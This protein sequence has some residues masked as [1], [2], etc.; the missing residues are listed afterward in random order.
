MFAFG[1]V[2][3]IA[4]ILASET[5]LIPVHYEYTYTQESFDI[6]LAVL[7][8]ILILI[9]QLSSNYVPLSSHFM[10]TLTGEIGQRAREIMRVI[11]YL[12]IFCHL[13]VLARIANSSAG[14]GIH[15]SLSTVWNGISKSYL[16]MRRN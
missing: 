5:S 13:Q 6:V 16:D 4:V 3:V 8:L 12:A 9:L 11:D 1:Y 10:C 14:F 15:V 7:I 2:V